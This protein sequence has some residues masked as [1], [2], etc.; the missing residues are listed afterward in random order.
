MQNTFSLHREVLLTNYLFFHTFT[1]TATIFDSRLLPLRRRNLPWF[2][3]QSRSHRLPPDFLPLSFTIWYLHT[4]HRLTFLTWQYLLSAAYF[5]LLLAKYSRE[6][7][8]FDPRVWS[9]DSFQILLHLTFAQFFCHNSPSGT[10]TLAEARGFQQVVILLN[11]RQGLI[12]QSLFD[13]AIH[14]QQ[15]SNFLIKQ[16][17]LKSTSLS[18]QNSHVLISQPIHRTTQTLWELYKQFSNLNKV[19]LR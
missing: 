3:F 11:E 12:T 16:S 18:S 2:S 19:S 8:L 4:L 14:S 5:S 9:K 13:A 1:L 17:F 7:L 6:K 10:Q 15:S